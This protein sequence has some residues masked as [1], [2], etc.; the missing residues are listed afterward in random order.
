MKKY[1]LL[2]I[3]GGISLL[4]IGCQPPMNNNTVGEYMTIINID[5]CEYISI[6]K[7]PNQSSAVLS[8]T[9]KGN[10]SNPIHIYKTNK[11]KK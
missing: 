6:E 8:V 3:V 4:S 11:L 2:L 9:H 1:I 7:Y 5:G 10:C